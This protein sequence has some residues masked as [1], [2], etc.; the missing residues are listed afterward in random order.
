MDNTTVRII[1]SVVF[2]IRQEIDM[3]KMKELS[4]L[5]QNE[6]TPLYQSVRELRNALYTEHRLVDKLS[7]SID[8]L[9]KRLDRLTDDDGK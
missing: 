9:T 2:T 7:K 1:R 4:I 8:I 6:I 5:V 3:G